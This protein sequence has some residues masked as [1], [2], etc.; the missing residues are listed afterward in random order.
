[1]HTGVVCVHMAW[2]D[3]CACIIWLV[4]GF[5]MFLWCCSFLSG[6]WL[7]FCAAVAGTAKPVPS[8]QAG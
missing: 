2:S 4:R 1:M 3:V 7:I 6:H 5:L 8:Y